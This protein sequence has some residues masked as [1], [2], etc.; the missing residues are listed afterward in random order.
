MPRSLGISCTKRPEAN[1]LDGYQNV[2]E[3]WIEATE[4]IKADTNLE[5]IPTIGMTVSA[6]KDSEAF[7]MDSLPGALEQLEGMINKAKGLI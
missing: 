4:Q 3:G 1:N 5:A 6:I 7:E 2:G